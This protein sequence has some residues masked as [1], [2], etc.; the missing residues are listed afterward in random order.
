MPVCDGF[1]C[2]TMIRTL[3]KMQLGILPEGAP[4]P[5]P[6]LI[7]ALTGLASRRDRDAAKAAGADH[8]CTKPLK[9]ARLKELLVE[10]GV[11]VWL[12]EDV[13]GFNYW[14][15][16]GWRGPKNIPDPSAR[17]DGLHLE[18]DIRF[19][20]SVMG[21]SSGWA[22]GWRSGMSIIIISSM[23][24]ITGDI[25]RPNCTGQEIIL[26]VRTDCTLIYCVSV[27]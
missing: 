15:I 19:W 5:A 18:Q 20:K 26:T 13:A 23:L 4:K 25:Y 3:E 10:W 8:F 1:Q 17:E 24:S 14:E 9:L 12:K 27:D 22:T 16:Y 2:T 11:G 7:V 6:A 21:L